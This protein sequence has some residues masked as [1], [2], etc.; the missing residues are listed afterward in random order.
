MSTTTA[1]AAVPQPAAGDAF[2]DGDDIMRAMAARLDYLFGES[3]E[4]TI[5][6]TAAN[7]KFTKVIN[8]GRTYKTPPRVVVGLGGDNYNAGIGAGVVTLYVDDVTTTTVTIAILSTSTA[9][10]QLT[11]IA[12]PKRTD[13][14][15]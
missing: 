8:F 7:T 11:W 15:P 3:G 10:R 2:A 1:F 13:V 6:P 12:K 5:Q 4:D 9:S 14:T